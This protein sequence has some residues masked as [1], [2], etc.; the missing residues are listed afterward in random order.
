MRSKK[1][2]VIVSFMI[3]I[4]SLNSISI[5]GIDREVGFEIN[6]DFATSIFIDFETNLDNWTLIYELPGAE[7]YI[8]NETSYDGN[9][10][11]CLTNRHRQR[12]IFDEDRIIKMTNNTMITFSWGFP[13]KDSHYIGILLGTDGPDLLLMSHFDWVYLNTSTLVIKYFDNEVINTWHY[14]TFNVSDI[15]LQEY[16]AIP[17]NI[18]YVEVNNRGIGTYDS[19]IPCDQVTYFD[20]IFISTTGLI[21]PPNPSP[22]PI[23]P[24][25]DPPPTTTDPSPTTTDPPPTTTDPTEDPS[26][27]P[28]TNQTVPPTTDIPTIFL[29]LPIYTVVFS[30]IFIVSIIVVLQKRKSRN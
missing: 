29:T 17:E 28:S 25:I 9:S 7:F 13:I 3:L 26:E 19:T 2:K 24:L 27:S 12:D 5:S 6:T 20:S 22:K 18:T 21:M 16:G 30:S 11:V 23:P 1:V 8:T 14:H 15:F 10:S 4:L